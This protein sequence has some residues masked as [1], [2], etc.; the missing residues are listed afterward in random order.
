MPPTHD[1]DDTQPNRNAPER[2]RRTYVPATWAAP[3]MG[4]GHPKLSG[5]ETIDNKTG[6]PA[7]RGMNR[8][9]QRYAGTDATLDANR[10]ARAASEYATSVIL[11]GAEGRYEVRATSGNNYDVASDTNDCDCPDQFRLKAS[12]KLAAYCKHCHLVRLALIDPLLPNG[13]KWS[14]AKLAEAIGID[15]RSAEILCDTGTVA[16]SKVHNV[17]VI[18][19]LTGGTAVTNQ[20]RKQVRALPYVTASWGIVAG[21][22]ATDPNFPD[23]KR[24]I[25]CTNNSGRTMGPDLCLV[26]LTFA[27]VTRWKN[28]DGYTQLSP[29]DDRPYWK[30]IGTVPNGGNFVVTPKWIGTSIFPSTWTFGIIEGIGAP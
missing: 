5:G 20:Q 12:G 3:G 24:T 9:D 28:A 29:P 17:W 11:L 10:A 15:E 27:T 2:N 21:F 1:E 4:A 26:I 22:Y 19:P 30:N 7:P 8:P 23:L 16:A 18:D 25:T 6:N 13:L 14:T